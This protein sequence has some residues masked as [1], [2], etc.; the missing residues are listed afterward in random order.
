MW[1]VRKH[2]GKGHTV[3]RSAGEKKVIRRSRGGEEVIMKAEE[4]KML[5]RSSDLT[6]EMTQQVEVLVTKLAS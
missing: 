3:R 6:S 5:Q 4:W 1:Q 2:W